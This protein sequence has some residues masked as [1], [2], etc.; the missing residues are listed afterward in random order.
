MYLLYTTSSAQMFWDL[1][2][3]EKNQQKYNIDERTDSNEN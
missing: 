1:E 2:E 3:N